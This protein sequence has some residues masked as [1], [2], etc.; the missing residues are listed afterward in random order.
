MNTIIDFIGTAII[1]AAYIFVILGA[2]GT[3]IW[4]FKNNIN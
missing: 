4:G 2:I 3:I 1:L